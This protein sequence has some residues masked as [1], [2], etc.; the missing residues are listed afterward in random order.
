MWRWTGRILIGLCA[1][2]TIAACS[3]AAYQWVSTRKALAETPRPGR[4]VDVGG[5][6]LH[7]W[8]T[9]AGHPSVVLETGLGGS[10]VGWGFVQPEVARIT[11]VCSPGRDDTRDAAASLV[12]LYDS[13]SRP[14]QA[15]ERRRRLRRFEAP[16]CH[17]SQPEDPSSTLRTPW[18]SHLSSHLTSLLTY[19]PGIQG[20]RAPEPKWHRCP[21]KPW[22]GS[23]VAWR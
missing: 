12:A 6:R 22:I 17:G 7:I 16:Y 19:T 4:L 9:G 18:P 13:W 3:G 15:A 8:C 20:N 21:C 5:H 10:T 11:Q 1:G 2:L 14:E 23:A